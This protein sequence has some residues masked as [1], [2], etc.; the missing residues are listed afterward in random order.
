MRMIAALKPGGWLLV[1][2]LVSPV[3]EAAATGNRDNELAQQSR[4]ALVEVLRRRGGDPVFAHR[5]AGLILRA[6]LT[7]VGSE[8]YFVPIRTAAVARLARANIDQIGARDDRD[9]FDQFGGT[10]PIPRDSGPPG[11][12]VSHIY[13]TDFRMGTATA[14]VAFERRKHRGRVPEMMRRGKWANRLLSLAVCVAARGRQDAGRQGRGP[15]AG[16]VR[17]ALFPGGSTLPAHV[18]ITKGICQRNGLRSSSQR[19]RICRCSWPHSP[20]ASTTSPWA[21]L[22][23]R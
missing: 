21:C 9:R 20:K 7:D 13:G 5:V 4:R 8:G 19:V 2:E 3:T 22:H 14:V 18:A 10:G 17:V 16:R 12:S 23:S 15:P 11:L 6:G 1:E